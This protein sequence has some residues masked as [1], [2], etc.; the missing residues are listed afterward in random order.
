MKETITYNKYGK[1]Y[2]KNFYFNISHSGRWV[3]LACANEDVGI[4]IEKIQEEIVV[5]SFFSEE[6]RRYI[7]EVNDGE[8]RERF[9]QV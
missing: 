6:E 9:T 3:V 7:N 1:P 5:E 4:D 2:L 8:K